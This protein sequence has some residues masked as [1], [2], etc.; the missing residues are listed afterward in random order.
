MDNAF[1][2]RAFPG[3]TTA[4]LRAKVANGCGSAKMVAEIA[5]REAVANGD[6]SQAST[7]ERLRNR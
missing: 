4:E 3:F 6:M 2:G 5:R 1:T 7:G